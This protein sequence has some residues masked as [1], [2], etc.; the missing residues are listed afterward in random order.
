MSCVRVALKLIVAGGR[1][2][3]RSKKRPPQRMAWLLAVPGLP[4][5]TTC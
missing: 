4:S 1:G 5:S 2:L 3:I